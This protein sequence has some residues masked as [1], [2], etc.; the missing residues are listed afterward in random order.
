[1]SLGTIRKV[2]SLIIF[3]CDILC[4]LCTFSLLFYLRLD[5]LPDYSSIDLWLI[6]STFITTLYLSGTYFKERSN[7]SPALPIR[8]F[9]ICL[10]GGVIC[11]LWVYLLGPLEFNSYFGRGVLPAGT[12]LLGI[13]STL[14]RYVVNN[15]YHQQEKGVSLLYLGYSKSCDLFLSELKNHSEIRSVHLLS[16]IH[17]KERLENLAIIDDDLNKR[18]L[19]KDWQAIIVDPEKELDTNEKNLL[20]SAR[21]SGTPV[22]SLAD[23]YESNWFMVPIDHISDEWFLRSQGF[24]MIEN[25]VSQ[26]IKRLLDVATSLVLIV[27]SA[28]II[29]ICATAILLS[30]RGPVF[31]KQTRVGQHGKFFTIY[32][33]RTMRTDAENNGAQWATEKDP[34][35]TLVGRFLR[36]SRLDELPQCWNVLIG[37][38]SFIGP[39]PERPEF[40]SKLA[41]AIPYYDLRHTVKPGVSGWA[42]VI[43]PYGASIDDSLKKLQYELYYIKHQSLLLDLNII[44]RTT[45]TVFQRAGR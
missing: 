31:F 41:S 1:M 16:K 13:F 26:R 44:V 28:P 27:I 39:R 37:D 18:I 21:L 43:F 25:P 2:R 17:P 22:V 5:R 45:F 34:R 10:V 7:V 32:K 19:D 4:A 29:L 38:M 9:F 20:I 30:S 12:V 15:I 3:L 40:T 33:L 24:S 11:I 36:R 14:I 42:Q 8:T 23:Y 6:V 35:V